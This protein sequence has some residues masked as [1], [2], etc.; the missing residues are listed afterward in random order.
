MKDMTDGFC[1]PRLT[2]RLLSCPT[3][4]FLIFLLIKENEEEKGAMAGYV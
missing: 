2:V 4:P 3:F 1:L